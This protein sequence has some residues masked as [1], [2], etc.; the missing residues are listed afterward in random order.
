MIELHLKR[1]KQLF[2][3]NNVIPKQHYMLHLPGQILSLGPLIRQ[4]CMR[5]ESKH[6]LFKQWSSKLNFRNVCK[7]LANR[8][9]LFECC[10]N[11]LG[12]EHPMF[13]HEKELGPVSEVTNIQ[14]IKAKIKYFLGIDCIRHAVSVKWLI[15]NSNKYVSERSLI[16]TSANGNVPV[17]GLIKNIYVVDSSLFCFEYQL[18]ETLDLNRDLLAYEIAVPNL[19]Q[20]TEFIDAEKLL[21]PMSYYPVSFKN[22]VYVLTKYNLEDVI[23]LKTGN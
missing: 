3:D 7:S 14:Y 5:F 1:F 18:Y 20:A 8:N 12:S 9:Q 17:F 11:E 4:M 2:P 13:A 15:F 22:S 23:A 6:C 10:Q 21:D 16:I 19:A